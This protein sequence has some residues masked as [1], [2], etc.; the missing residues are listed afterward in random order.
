MGTPATGTAPI[1]ITAAEKDGSARLL[2]F[3]GEET[4]GFSVQKTGRQYRRAGMKIR[5]IKYARHSRRLVSGNRD[6][7]LERRNQNLNPFLKHSLFLGGYV[8]TYSLSLGGV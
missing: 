2:A 4:G 8:R 6:R 5:G 3:L 1:Q 7:A